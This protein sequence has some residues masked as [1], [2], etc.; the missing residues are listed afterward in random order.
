MKKILVA[1]DGSDHAMRAL[2]L[3]AEIAAK[4]EAEL[5]LLHVI[6][7]LELPDNMKN[8]ADSEHMRGGADE[9]LHKAAGFILDSAKEKAKS[10]GVKTVTCK[11][12]VG[13]PARTIAKYAADNNVDLI[14][15]GRRGLGAGK[16]QLIGEVTSLLSGGVARRVE[17]LA[18]CP[19]LTVV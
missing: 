4:F 12:I 6:R 3:A 11:D 13:P 2:G 9:I 8:F 10:I 1:L 7:K 18:N 16:S 19:C 5:M 17:G 15:I 14:A